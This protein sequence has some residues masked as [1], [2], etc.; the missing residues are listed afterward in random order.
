MPSSLMCQSVCFRRDFT[1]RPAQK[2]QKDSLRAR[3]VRFG[4]LE[5][6][7]TER[8]IVLLVGNWQTLIVIDAIIEKRNEWINRLELSIQV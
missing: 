1:L 4:K 7:I 8:H 5:K 3:V 2:T 6:F